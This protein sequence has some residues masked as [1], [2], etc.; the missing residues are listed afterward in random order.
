MK[1]KMEM[2]VS[3]EM[4]FNLVQ[5]DLMTMGVK[6]TRKLEQYAMSILS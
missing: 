5:D 2:T 6:R 4:T 3:A 1:Y